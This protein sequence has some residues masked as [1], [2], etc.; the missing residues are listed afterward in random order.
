MNEVVI[1]T[2]F[3]DEIYDKPRNYITRFDSNE[4]ATIKDFL[5]L[6]GLD[7]NISIEP[8]E[9]TTINLDRW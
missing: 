9:N 1:R 6:I 4:V 7:G 8:L 5:D 3:S 2:D